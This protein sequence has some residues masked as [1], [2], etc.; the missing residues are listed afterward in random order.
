MIEAEYD[1]HGFLGMLHS[2][3]FDIR[4]RDGF[5]QVLESISTEEGPTIDRRLVA[6]LWYMPSIIEW[7]K[8]AIGLEYHAELDVTVNL[9][10]NQIER[11]LG[12]P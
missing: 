9:A 4:A 3:R 12:V 1:D 7:H 2:G 8:S 5:L 10:R 11:L 6:L